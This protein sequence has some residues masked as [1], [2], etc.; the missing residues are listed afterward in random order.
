MQQQAQHAPHRPQS[1]RAHSPSYY[2]DIF[3]K[4]LFVPRFELP[5]KIPRI[6]LRLLLDALDPN[7]TAVRFN[8]VNIVKRTSIMRYLKTSWMGVLRRPSL[9]AAELRN[10]PSTRQDLEDILTLELDRQDDTHGSRNNWRS[11]FIGALLEG[12]ILDWL[13]AGFQRPNWQTDGPL[14]DGIV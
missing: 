10:A 6:T 12:A 7:Y 4:R 2:D 11:V 14:L 13:L 5:G 9:A 1:G 8:M 3:G